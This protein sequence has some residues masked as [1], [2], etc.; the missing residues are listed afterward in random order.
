M[1]T[2]THFF[3]ALTLPQEVKQFLYERTLL[4]REHVSFKKW[5]HQDDYHITLA[6]LGHASESMRVDAV[7]RVQQA[8]KE[9]RAFTLSLDEMGTFGDREL[10]RILWT[11]VKREEQLYEIQKRVYTACLEAGFKLDKKPFKPH[12][13]LARKFNGTLFTLENVQ[14]TADIKQESMKFTASTVTLYQSHLGES[15]SYEPVFSI[16]L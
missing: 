8:L 12:I 5:L 13:T 6:F 11:S 15:P 4:L 3:F 10:P 1:E 14:H 2:K 7:E 9:K 16:S